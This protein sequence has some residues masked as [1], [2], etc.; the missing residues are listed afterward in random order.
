M[1][2][3]KKHI[4]ILC[5]FV[6]LLFFSSTN[7]MAGELNLSNLEFEAKLNVDGSMDVIEK[8]DIRIEDTNTVYKSFETDNEKYSRI[9]DVTVKEITEQGIK[10]FTQVYEWQYHVTKDCY[11]GTFN[12]DGDFEIGWGVGLDSGS[13]R[14]QY[15]IQYT[16]K[17]VIKKAN[18]YAEL[19]WKFVGDNFSIPVNNI[20]GKVYLPN[21]V[22]NMEDIKV[23]GHTKFLNGL[24]NATNKN[25]IQFSGTDLPSSTFFEIRI[26]FPTDLVYYSARTSNNDILNSVI[27]EE[28]KWANAAN[29]KRQNMKLTLYQMKTEPQVK[30]IEYLIK[31][32]QNIFL[33]QI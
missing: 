13:D 5:F 6:I 31:L 25:E 12:E 26:L 22:D 8:W 3:I 19:Y 10:S 30:R 4:I 7:V 17:D 1:K 21:Y 29:E 14:R 28:T 23:W 27:E 2:K 20:K 15:I 24:I 32:Q 11:Y 9:T 33:V 16:V 18:D